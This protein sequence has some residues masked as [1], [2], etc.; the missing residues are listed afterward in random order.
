MCDPNL[1]I[2]YFSIAG[3]G[4]MNDARAFRR[5]TGLKV[6]LNELE[7]EFFCS[8]DNAYPMNNSMMIPYSDVQ[9]FE[10]YRLVY[11]FYLSQLRIRI[12]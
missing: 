4:K 12:E 5:L 2:S 3:P 1:R 10:E 8:G 7:D 6:W 9:I 11:N